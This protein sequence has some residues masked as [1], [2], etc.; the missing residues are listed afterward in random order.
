VNQTSQTRPRGDITIDSNWI[1]TIGMAL[2]FAFIAFLLCWSI[3]DLLFDKVDPRLLRRVPNRWLDTVTY[4][5][6]AVYCFLFAYSF[7]AKHLKIAFSL[8]GAKYLVLVAVPYLHIAA[9]VRHSAAT[10][11]AIASQIAYAAILFAIA[12]WFKA[13]VRRAPQR[14]HGAES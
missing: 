11:G 1:V 14:D 4:V 3:R 12:Q 8:L 2:L 7:S 13:V 6:G 5:F 10:A 9:D